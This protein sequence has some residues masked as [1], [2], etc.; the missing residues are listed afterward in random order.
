MYTLNFFKAHWEI[1]FYIAGH[2]C[3]MGQFHMVM[4]SVL[5]RRYTQALV[6]FHTGCLPVFI[7]F[8]L[9]TGFHE[10]LHF[11]LLKLP[12]TENEPTCYDLITESLP[13]LCYTKGDLHTSC[14]LHIE[15]IHKNTLGRFRA[16]VYNICFLGHRANF[17]REHQ[18]ELAHICPVAGSAY[19]TAYFIVFN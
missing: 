18:V 10:K 16:Q 2:I 8:L 14:L 9:C 12:H 17:C 6:P 13:G 11:H 7:P 15:E 5:I 1:V 4:K 3:I 19:S